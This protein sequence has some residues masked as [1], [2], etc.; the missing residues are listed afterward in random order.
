[1]KHCFYL[2]LLGFLVGFITGLIGFGAGMIMVSF[3]LGLKMHT[4]VVAT[5]S[6]FILFLVSSSLMTTVYID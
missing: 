2:G 6:G 1:M 3:L 4:R 5:T